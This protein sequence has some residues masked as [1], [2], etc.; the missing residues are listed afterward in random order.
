M[1]ADAAKSGNS[2]ADK[3]PTDNAPKKA[4]RSQELRFKVTDS[5]KQ[6]FKQAAKDLGIKKTA[7]L[8]R[9]LAEWQDRRMAADGAPKPAPAKADPR[10]P[11]SGR[12]PARKAKAVLR[13]AAK[14]VAG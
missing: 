10:K 6:R 12:K 14:P 7:L 13:D 11:R 3:P 8:E 5:F 4:A 1:H 9:L 2:V